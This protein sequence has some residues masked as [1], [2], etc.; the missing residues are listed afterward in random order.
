MK[1]PLFSVGYE[2]NGTTGTEPFLMKI[3]PWIGV[4]VGVAVGLGC[5]AE[6][7]ENSIKN[8]SR[9]MRTR[10][11]KERRKHLDHQRDTF[12]TA[13]LQ[14]AASCLRHASGMHGQR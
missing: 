1:L 11:R 4:T 9:G 2:N 10:G 14:Y 8:L 3:G 7:L 6:K 13:K 5:P 12:I